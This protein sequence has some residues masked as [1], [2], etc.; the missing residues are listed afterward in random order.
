MKEGTVK[1]MGLH[2]SGV[3]KPLTVATEVAVC[4]RLFQIPAVF[5]IHADFS[6]GGTVF[7]ARRYA[8][9]V[10]YML[11]SSVRLSDR[12]SQVGVLQRWLILGPHKHGIR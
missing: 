12:P 1:Q 3:F 8:S 5:V 4:G 9:A 7:T 10:A 11:S 6:R 2:S